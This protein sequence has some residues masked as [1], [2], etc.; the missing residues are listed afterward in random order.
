MEGGSCPPCRRSAA[1]GAV[2]AARTSRHDDRTWSH[3]NSW[4]LMHTACTEPSSLSG[5]VGAGP[6]ALGDAQQEWAGWGGRGRVSAQG[7][8]RDSHRSKLRSSTS[9]R[10]GRAARLL[11]CRRCRP[12]QL[13]ECRGAGHSPLPPP[14]GLGGS[15]FQTPD[16]RTHGPT[17]R[18]GRRPAQP[19]QHGA[20]A[21]P[22][23]AAA[24]RAG[25]IR[26]AGPGPAHTLARPARI[27]NGATDTDSLRVPGAQLEIPLRVGCGCLVRTSRSRQTRNLTLEHD[28]DP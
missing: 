17:G 4:A 23:A 9:G 10:S 27:W 11:Q 1:R 7:R 24:P 13:L 6:G 14:A 21:H 28:R 18:S 22:W 12:G 19:L 20:P 26:P 15:Q 25:P 3:P 5:G 8:P 16:R 2:S